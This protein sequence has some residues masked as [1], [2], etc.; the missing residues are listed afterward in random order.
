VRAKYIRSFIDNRL[1]ACC[2]LGAVTAGLDEVA[3]LNHLLQTN[4][5]QLVKF[6]IFKRVKEDL[7][8]GKLYNL[9]EVY[10]SH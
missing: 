2:V 3:T 5:H 9:V 1:A 7:D 8:A 10:L 4:P 6:K